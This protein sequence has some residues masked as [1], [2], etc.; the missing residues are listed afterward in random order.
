MQ[1][2]LRVQTEIRVVLLNDI[3][4]HFQLSLCSLISRSLADLKTNFSNEEMFSHMPTYHT[5]SILTHNVSTDEMFSPLK[6]KLV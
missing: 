6:S 1:G 2:R 5:V 3:S 4:R